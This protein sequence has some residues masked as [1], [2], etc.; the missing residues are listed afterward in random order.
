M[1][2]KEGITRGVFLKRFATAIG[3][4][5]A[6]S[7][8][9]CSE[10]SALVEPEQ[11]QIG[12]AALEAEI[13]SSSVYVVKQTTMKATNQA[14]ATIP[15]ATLVG[16]GDSIDVVV[17]TTRDET[18]MRLQA[19]GVKLVSKTTESADVLGL[20]VG[21]SLLLEPKATLKGF[22]K[23]DFYGTRRRFLEPVLWRGDQ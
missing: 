17:L 12:S 4:L 20:L 10:S 9:G 8:W 5:S 14:L 1:L 6:F 3:G 7:L 23:L 19:K 22:A 15:L 16:G 18:G 2:N 21:E 11:R 13:L